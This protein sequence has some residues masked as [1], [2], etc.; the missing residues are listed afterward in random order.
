M[1]EEQHPKEKAIAPAYQEVKAI[2]KQLVN[3]GR[4]T[5][6][7]IDEQLEH[8]PAK[9]F[10]DSELSALQG[11]LDKFQADWEENNAAQ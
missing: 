8:K 11:K 9:D 4:L 2:A 1:S 10:K 3:S 5:P 6:A 7:W